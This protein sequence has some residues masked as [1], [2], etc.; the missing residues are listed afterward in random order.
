MAKLKKVQDLVLQILV[1]HPATRNSDEVL[2]E[3]V[4]QHRGSEIGVDISNMP[5]CHV[6]RNLGKWGIPSFK[7]V[8]RARRKVQEH[9]PNLAS[10]KKIAQMRK[11]QEDE[12]RKYSKGIC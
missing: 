3:C 6:L 1:E 12:Y 2:Y 5:F 4:V 11:E 7:S 9:Y 8:E 10:D